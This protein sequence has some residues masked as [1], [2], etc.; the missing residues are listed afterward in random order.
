MT[1]EQVQ[2]LSKIKELL[3]SGILSQE[4]FDLEKKKILDRGYHISD[5]SAT[6][7]NGV[8]PK[9]NMNAKE[10]KPSVGLNILS[11]FFGIVGIILY[12]VTRDQYPIRAKSNLKWGIVGIVACLILEIIAVLSY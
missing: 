1:N 8:S 9:T 3:D 7:L 11:F 2:S 6:V 4:E 10:D 12:F 5:D